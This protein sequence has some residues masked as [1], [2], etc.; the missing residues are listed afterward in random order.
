VDPDAAGANATLALLDAHVE[1][2]RGDWPAL[3]TTDGATTY[4]QL[5]GLVGRAGAALRTLGVEPGQRVAILLPD[6]VP[7]VAACLGAWRIGAVAVPLNTRLPPRA[8]QEILEDSGARVLIADPALAA[9]LAASGPPASVRVV[10]PDALASGPDLAGPAAVGGEAMAVWLYTSGTTGAPKGAVHTHGHLL[11]GLPYGVDVLGASPAD[12]VLV[13]SRLFFAYALG[14]ALLIPLQVGARS[15]LDPAWPDPASVEATLRRFRPTLLFSVPTFYAR[16]LAAGLPRSSFASVRCA[17]SAGERLPEEIYRGVR[18]RYG[19]EILD[20]LGA[21]ETIFMVLSNRPG[22]SRAGSAGTPVPVT[23]ARVLDAEGREVPPG[24]EGVLHVRTPSG[25]TRYWNRPEPSRRAFAGEWFCTGDVCLRDADG[26][27]HHRG[28]ED[29]RFKVAGLWVAPG[30]VEAVLL[31]HPDVIDAGVVG[32]PDGR[33]LVKA[34]AFVV[35]KTTVAPGALVE[36]L[37]RLTAEKLAAHQRPRRLE[38]VAELPR[39]A[40]GKL[41]RFV[42]RAGR[43]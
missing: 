16:L 15:F 23:E 25:S 38:V 42:L 41:Q 21:T 5:L 8:W 18:E 43:A 24:V 29:D 26:F 39:T 14:N 22:Q 7:W 34:V 2:G 1:A 10:A 6:G 31:A 19:V 37:T 3:V 12:R 17:V 4:R 36:A 32:M 33:G 13:T 11:A 30:D 20:G 28:R 9:P 27:F 35:P 40:T